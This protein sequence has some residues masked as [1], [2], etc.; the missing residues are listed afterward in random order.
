MSLKKLKKQKERAKRLEADA[1]RQLKDGADVPAKVNN[2]L[3]G[4][5]TIRKSRDVDIGRV[6]R[7]V[8]EVIQVVNGK[9]AD[10]SLIHKPGSDEQHQTFFPVI[11]E[12]V[13]K[14]DKKGSK[15]L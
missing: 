15:K 3:V 2:F 5:P 4:K 6:S 1:A 10:E 7:N 11:Q 12:G 9:I 8:N 14:K 13:T